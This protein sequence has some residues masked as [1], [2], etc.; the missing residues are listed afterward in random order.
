MDLLPE[1]IKLI[2]INLPAILTL[3]LG[4]VATRFLLWRKFKVIL[5]DIGFLIGSVSEAINDDQLTMDE[6]NT[7]I[8][9]VQR[10]LDDLK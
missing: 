5:A 3:I 2:Q 9:D 6:V 8:A 10:L 4:V 1:L 7:I